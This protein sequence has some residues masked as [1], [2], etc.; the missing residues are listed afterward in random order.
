MKKFSI[1]CGLLIASGSLFAQQYTISTFAGIGASPGWSGDSGPALSAQFTTPTRVLPDSS[2]NVY[3]TDLGNSSIREVFANGTVTSVT[4][5][6]SPGLS[7]D[8]GGAQ[9]AQ[10]SA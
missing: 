3:I 2:G 6:G 7:G 9:G 1:A 4:G 5:N 8:G 10:I